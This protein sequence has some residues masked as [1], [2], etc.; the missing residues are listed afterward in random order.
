[1]MAKI[2]QAHQANKHRLD[3]EDFKPG[4]LMMLS[5]LNCRREHK[6]NE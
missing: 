6:S 2:A 5:T 1:M 4:D 3:D